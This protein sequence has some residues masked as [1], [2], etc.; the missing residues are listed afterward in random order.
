MQLRTYIVRRLLGVL[1]LLLAVSFFAF[2]LIQRSP[3]DP[4]EVA[5]RVNA[6]RPTPELIAETRAELGL[7]K[8]FLSRYVTWLGRVLQ[9][10]F[11]RRYVDRKPVGQEMAKAL[12]P[13]LLLAATTAVLML[14]VSICAALVGAVFEG[15][16]PDILLRGCIFLGTSMPAF[17]AGLL[18]IWLFAVKLD[19]FPTSGLSGPASLVLPALTLS[20]PYISA[21]ARLLRNSMVQTK[22]C[23]FVLYARACG[24]KRSAI[25][26]HIFRNSLQ[27]SLTALG[28][29]LPKLV[30][31]TFVVECIFAWPGLGRLCVTAIFNRDFPMIQAYVLLMA[32]LFVLCNLAM[33]ICS[34]LVDPR[35]REGGLR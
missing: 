17:W 31:G 33:D 14:T 13:T 9:G 35:L 15:R 12:P 4:A 25:L 26:R 8:P 10:D 28:M 27:S 3:S 32:V 22:Q 1:P 23:N 30:A 11:G 20:L 34:A 2:V 24:R 19:L 5:I 7:D 18:L 6:M 16:I 29:S 21:Y